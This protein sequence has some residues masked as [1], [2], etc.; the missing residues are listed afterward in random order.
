MKVVL[1]LLKTADPY[2]RNEPERAKGGWT[3][4]ALA[5]SDCGKSNAYRLPVHK[6]PVHVEYV[7]HYID[8]SLHKVRLIFINGS[9]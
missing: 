1:H 3:N 4:E 8:K 2:W 5:V 9:S 7:E 6:L